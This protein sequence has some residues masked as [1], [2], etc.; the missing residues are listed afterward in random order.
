MLKAVG[1]R[2]LRLLARKVVGSEVCV[3]R[4]IVIT[5]FR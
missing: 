5:R 3:F 2:R 4:T 1:L